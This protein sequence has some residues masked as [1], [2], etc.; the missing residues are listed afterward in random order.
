MAN[1]SCDGEDLLDLR[2]SLN[3]VALPETADWFE[4]GNEQPRK[5]KRRYP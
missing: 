4:A 3:A 5:L 2:S 1:G